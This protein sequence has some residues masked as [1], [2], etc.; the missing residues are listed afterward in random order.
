MQAGKLDHHFGF[1]ISN[2]SRLSKERDQVY[3]YCCRDFV[4]IDD[5]A[6]VSSGNSDAWKASLAAITVIAVGGAAINIYNG[7]ERRL[8]QLKLELQYYLDKFLES[9]DEIRKNDNAIVQTKD[10]VICILCS[11]C[12]KCVP[13]VFKG[14]WL[15]PDNI[16]PDDVQKKLKEHNHEQQHSSPGLLFWLNGIPLIIAFFPMVGP[17]L[18]SLTSSP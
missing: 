13:D 2:D 14:G 5:F 9:N 10:E 11:Q 4:C 16:D 17:S 3:R 7:R 12:G 18:H 1:E 8:Q 15:Y 6:I